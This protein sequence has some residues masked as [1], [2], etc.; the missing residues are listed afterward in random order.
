MDNHKE[1]RMPWHYYFSVL[2]FAGV[3][4]GEMGDKMQVCFTRVNCFSSFLH[5]PADINYS[6]MVFSRAEFLTISLPCKLQSELL[7]NWGNQCSK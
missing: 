2:F 7:P 6:L 4:L 5:H 1:V 3:G